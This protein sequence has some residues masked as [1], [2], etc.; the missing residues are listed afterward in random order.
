MGRL[1][2]HVGRALEMSRRLKGAGTDRDALQNALDRLAD[3]VAFIGADDDIIHANDA[4]RTISRRGDGIEIRRG[5]LAFASSGAAAGIGQAV[6]AAIQLRNGEAGPPIPFDFAVPRPSGAPAYVVSIR[7]LVGA[8]LQIRDEARVIV[9][10]RDPASRDVPLR[11]LCQAFGL[12]DA[13]A[14]LARALQKGISL[15]DYA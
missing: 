4:M 3:G 8:D 6:A 12:T 10:V 5:R 13:E 9:F 7:P 11:L 14:G 1:A 2:P 15:G